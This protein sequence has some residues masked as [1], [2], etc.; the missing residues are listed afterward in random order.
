MV[1][2]L[3][4]RGAGGA[5]VMSIVA[6]ASALLLVSISAASDFESI[7]EAKIAPLT[8]E[9]EEIQRRSPDDPVI[10]TH[11]DFVALVRDVEALTTTRSDQLHQE[12][13]EPQG[14]VAGQGSASQPDPSSM[15][16][17]QIYAEFRER[18]AQILPL[19]APSEEQAKVL[20]RYC[21]VV[22]EVGQ[23]YLA[24]RVAA[25]AATDQARAD[26]AMELWA[27]LPWLMVSDAD[28]SAHDRDALSARWK[29][30]EQLRVFEDFALVVE[31]Y[32]TAYA[33]HEVRTKG[34]T[35]RREDFVDYLAGNFERLVRQ[36]RYQSATAC[37]R[38]AIS[39]AERSGSSERALGFRLELAEFLHATGRLSLAMAEAKKVLDAKD[40]P[41]VAQAAVLRLRY[42]FEN[43]ELDRVIAEASSYV[44]Q[45]Q[46]KSQEP[47]IRF[48]AWSAVY[49]K[50][51]RKKA[52]L[53][54]QEFF[55]KYP[56]HIL[57][58][59]MLFSELVEL[60]TQDEFQR[61]HQMIDL[62]ESK[63]PDSRVT[64]KVKDIRIRL[65]EGGH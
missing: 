15:D 8:R 5:L 26:S 45:D 36:S 32:R 46:C 34:D 31:R 50:G 4:G 25:I 39:E 12:A 40:A 41:H 9:A 44:A 19:K 63:Y 55:Q 29:R 14:A 16:A 43:R 21:Q 42:L 20:Q 11:M 64:P 37:L 13:K 48:M 24:D 62:I 1:R 54:K 52:E 22:V 35:K 18:F 3:L 2:M 28:W 10:S 33:I 47:E 17:A 65:R 60:L 61:S 58:A 59:D 53:L 56:D 7:A 30:P 49:A 23:V 6:V 27:V 51:D 57:R 38:M